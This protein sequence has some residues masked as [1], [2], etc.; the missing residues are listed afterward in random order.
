MPASLLKAIKLSGVCRHSASTF[1]GLTSE[2]F[3]KNPLNEPVLPYLKG[4]EERKALEVELDKLSQNPVEVP[5][6]IGGNKVFRKE[7]SHKQLMPFNHAKTIAYFN[8]A[9]AD[10]ITNSI[11]SA[12]EAREEWERKPLKE[13]ADIFLHAA[14]LCAGKYRMRLNAATMLGQAKTIQQAEIDSACELVD[15]LRFNAYFAFEVCKYQP[16]STKIYSDRLI[17]RGLEGFVAAIAPFNFTAIGGNLATAPALMGNVVL[18]KPSDT[19]VL[20]NYIAYEA[21]LEAGIPSGVIS[22]LPSDGPTFGNT[23]CSNHHLTGINFTGSMPTFLSLYNSVANNMGKYVTFPR[24]VGECGGKNFHFVHPS[25]NVDI[26]V[27]CTLRAAYEYQGQKC[28][29]VFV[30]QSLWPKIKDGL[31][32]LVNQIKIGDVRDGSV[33]MSS[34]IDAKSFKRIKSYID[35]AKSGENGMEIVYVKD[36]NSNSL[37]RKFL[38]QQFLDTAKDVL[39]DAVG[40]LYLNDKCTGAIVGQQPFGGARQSGTNDKAGGLHY[41]LRWTSPQTIKETTSPQTE[42]RYSNMD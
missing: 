18:W 38:A 11:L 37:L 32:D 21:L 17:Y 19:A 4:S 33:F 3:M 36:V 35:Y 34:V 7:S 9:T 2:Q 16:I 41:V 29:L 28:I 26:V 15:F 22:F 6:V 23:I 12:L 42:W 25:A 8:H 1:G 10:D 39:R 13:R 14:D 24:L 31:V 30:P 40:N 20:S 27:P 5:L